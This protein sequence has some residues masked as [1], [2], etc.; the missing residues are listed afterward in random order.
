MK[1]KMS[2]KKGPKG[3]DLDDVSAAADQQLSVTNHPPLSPC[4][5]LLDN[6]AEHRSV[7][8][9]S[10]SLQVQSNQNLLS[11][12]AVAIQVGEAGV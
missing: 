7:D 6:A 2:Q 4:P 10:S 8:L 12:L 3:H 9:P 1:M 5:N 11:Q